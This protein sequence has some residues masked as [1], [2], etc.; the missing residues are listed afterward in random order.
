MDTVPTHPKNF[1]VFFGPPGTGKTTMLSRLVARYAEYEGADTLLLTSFTKA[2]A[3]ELA[4]RDLAVATGSIGTLHSHCFQ[5]L[6]HPTIAQSKTTEWNAAF[7]RYAMS[8]GGAAHDLNDSAKTAAQHGRPDERGPQGESLLG[9]AMLSA[10]DLLRAALQPLSTA[11][12]SV[13]LFVGHYEMWKHSHGYLDYTDLLTHGLRRL[14]MA[15]GRPRTLIVDEAQ[16]LSLLQWAL[17]TQ[18][19]HHAVRTIAGGDDDQALYRWAGADAA[20]LLAADQES[21]SV[22]PKSYRLPNAIFDYAQQFLHAIR[23]REPKAWTSN[24]LP[25]EHVPLTASW[26]N[27]ES[28]RPLIERALAVPDQTFLVLAPCSYMLEPIVSMLRQDGLPFANPWRRRR[29]DWNPLFHGGRGIGSVTRLLDFLRD[30]RR[31]WTGRELGTWAKTIR[32]RGNLLPGAE[33]FLAVHEDQ[34]T[35]CPLS[36]LE[37]ILTP[38]ALQGALNGGISWLETH[39]LK[40]Y[41]TGMAFPLRVYQRFGRSAI[42]ENPRIMVGTCHS[43]KGGEADEVVL[44]RELSRAFQQARSNGGDEADGVERM[45]YVGATRSR[46]TLY[47]I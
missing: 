19:S 22:L 46:H 40:Q 6:D 39:M 12:A 47:T 26:R 33:S 42:A 4:G 44:F 38:A 35:I 27:P 21:K 37:K 15:P 13:Q 11:P 24:G 32:K 17:I 28:V 16:D 23:T 18:W 43:V 20:P 9:D 5:G 14:R 1:Q 7:P 29:G 3:H 36:M 41:A 34:D 10:Y 31:L 2:A 45:L 25:G 8:T 30:P